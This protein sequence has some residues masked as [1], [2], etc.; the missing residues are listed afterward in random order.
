MF[1]APKIRWLLTHLASG[2]DLDDVAVGTIDAWLIWR[3][4][5]GRVHACDAGN[6]SRTLLYDVVDLAWSAELCALFEVPMTALPEVRRSDES[7]RR[8]P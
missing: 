2:I 8:G 5:G 1:S 4:T 6:A 7:L 3:L